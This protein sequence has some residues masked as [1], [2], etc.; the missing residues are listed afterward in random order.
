[1]PK[2]CLGKRPLC[3]AALA[4]PGERFVLRVKGSFSGCRARSP[5]GGLSLDVAASSFVDFLIG[6]KHIKWIINWVPKRF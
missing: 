1:M 5:G 3:R 6:N 2:V 4:H